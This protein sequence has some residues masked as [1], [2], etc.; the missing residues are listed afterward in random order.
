M[1]QKTVDLTGIQD[2]DSLIWNATSGKFVVGPPLVQSLAIAYP[3][4]TIANLPT[5]PA[6]GTKV[7]VRVGSGVNTH[8]EV[9]RYSSASALWIGEAEYVI[10]TQGDT[11]AMDLGN[12]SASQMLV[13]SPVDNAVPYGKSHDLLAGSTNLSAAAFAG[14]TGVVT[15]G[16]T[17]SPHSFPFT[18]SGTIQI[19]DNF[20]TYT[21]LTST[22]FTGCTLVQ[23]SGGTIPANEW[24]TQGYPGGW[25]FNV[26]SV[27][28]A[29]DLFAAGLRIQ[30][31]VAALMNSAP[32]EFKM[33]VGTHWQQYDPGDG[34]NPP[35]IPPSGGMGVS[36]T[37]TSLD[38]TGG[39]Q[40][41][42][43]DFYMT[44]MVDGSGNPTWKNWPLALPT[45][46]FLVPKVVAKMASG[47]LTSGSVLDYKHT[48]RWVADPT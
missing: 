27:L 33:T 23:G 32:G 21:G 37:I 25:G 17:T 38:N 40:G 34:T 2:G 43:R 36:N 19:R 7:V 4:Q 26:T 11:W 1:S 41:G 42:E 24:V 39:T 15:V 3:G 13:F 48:I 16:D 6:D 18:A 8:Q 30:E 5:T 46:H 22:T 10:V 29:D 44:E 31:K 9:M 47:A 20:V 28:F 14:G 12:R 35:T 45:K